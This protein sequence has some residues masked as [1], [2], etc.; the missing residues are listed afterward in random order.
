MSSKPSWP[1]Q[2]QVW[3]IVYQ[4]SAAIAYCHSGLYRLQSGATAIE[5]TDKLGLPRTQV[6]HRDVKPRNGAF[7]INMSF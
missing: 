2:Q 1:S 5:K 6:L 7:G 3:S 4:L